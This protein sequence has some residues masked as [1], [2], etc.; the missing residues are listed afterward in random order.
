[1]FGFL[2]G[3]DGA[4]RLDQGLLFASFQRSLLRGFLAVQARL[5]G[6]PLEEYIQPVG[7][8]FF[9]ALPGVRD[10]D[11]WFGRALLADRQ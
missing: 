5:K 2:R 9:F 6:E 7:G 1:V 4:G 10:E 3:F 11:D 8:G